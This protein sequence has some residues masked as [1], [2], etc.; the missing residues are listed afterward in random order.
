MLDMAMVSLAWT[1]YHQ[2]IMASDSVGRPVQQKLHGK[3]GEQ[4]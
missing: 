2:S 1:G 3:C 4:K